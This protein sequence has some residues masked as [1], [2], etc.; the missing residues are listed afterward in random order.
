MSDSEGKI[1]E[2]GTRGPPW[3][4]KP[5]DAP[6]RQWA[7]FTSLEASLGVTNRD[8]DGELPGVRATMDE[9]YAQEVR[10]GCRPEVARAQVQKIAMSYHRDVASGRDAYPKRRD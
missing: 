4:D 2:W 6:S 9:I 10:G 1:S 3:K 8:I 7:P 5:M